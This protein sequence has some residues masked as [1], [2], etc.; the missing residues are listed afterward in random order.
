MSWVCNRNSLVLNPLKIEDVPPPGPLLPLSGGIGR[1]ARSH[2]HPPRGFG[3]P[4]QHCT[5]AHAE[6]LTVFQ[7]FW[8]VLDFDR[9]LKN[10]EDIEA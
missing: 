8:N 9:M 1:A 2:F 7:W 5:R 6:G 4:T 3:A 10:V